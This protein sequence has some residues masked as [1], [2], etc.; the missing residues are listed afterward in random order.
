MI[1]FLSVAVEPILVLDVVRWLK[2]DVC[3]WPRRRMGVLQNFDNKPYF[4][5]FSHCFDL[6][7]RL[8]LPWFSQ[9]KTTLK[10]RKSLFAID[11]KIISS[12]SI[13]YGYVRMCACTRFKRLELNEALFSFSAMF[14]TSYTSFVIL[15]KMFSNKIVWYL[16]CYL[17]IPLFPYNIF[18]TEWNHYGII[19]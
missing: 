14:N 2:S 6:F 4:Q 3:K 19:K 18:G 10:W 16:I 1:S 15:S 17:V 5:K 11:L 8:S 13:E 9:H 7:R 12:V